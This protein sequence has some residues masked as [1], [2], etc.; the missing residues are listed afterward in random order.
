[1]KYIK[2][3]SQEKLLFPYFIVEHAADAIFL[4][5]SKACIRLANEAACRSLAYS[6]EELLSL[7][8]YDIAP[9]IQKDGWT[10][11]W[12][13]INKQK[14][15]TLES[16]HRTKDGHIFPV[17]VS[18]NYIEFEGKAYYCALVRDI[19]KRLEAEATLRESEKRFKDIF[20]AVNDGII[21]V[22]PEKSC[23]FDAN[24]KAVE[25][26]GYKRSD[27]IGMDIERIHP[28]EMKQ[29]RRTLKEVLLGAPVLTDELSCLRGDKHRVPAE[30]SFSK[31]QLQDKTYVMAMIRDI[32][33]RKNAEKALREALTKVEQLKSRLQAENIYLQEEIKLNHN[34]E[35]II[36]YSKA[37][38]G[39][40]RKVELVAS[41][42]ATVLILG[43][44]GT[45]KELLARSVHNISERRDRPLVKVNCAALPSNLIES[46]LFGHEKGA[47]TGAHSQ[48]TGRFELADGGTIFLDEVGDLP[49]ELQS[50]LLRVLQEGEFEPLGSSKTRKVNVRVIAATNRD[51]EEAKANGDFREDLYYRLNVF[52]IKIPPLRERKE[53]IPILTKHFVEKYNTGIGKKIENIPQTVLD[54]LQTY[55]WPGN[56]RELENIIERSVIISQGKQLNLGDWLPIASTPSTDTTIS[57]LED[58][59]RKHIIDTLKSTG[60]RISG[61]KGAA[62]ILN[63][64]PT[65]LES[66][67]KKLNIKRE[68]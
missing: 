2:E 26:L 61:E 7:A 5:D 58:L 49:I 54:T 63:L 16:R 34:F 44:T 30:I 48:R 42:D 32:T 19:T 4:V 17:E 43:E 31:L 20:S 24:Q 56:V 64:K 36:S 66:R 41:T 39:V 14:S 1:M 27:V 52:P 55:H 62:K 51:L 9:D 38:K 10:E 6:K 46:E 47:F 35:E 29:L 57:T 65:T 28:E 22:D 12:A 21:I 68:Q 33:E 11:Q 25:M 23:I 8:V 45:G 50:R 53:D 3:A 40:L 67:M 13:M 18:I 59:E 60:W 15:F 37:L